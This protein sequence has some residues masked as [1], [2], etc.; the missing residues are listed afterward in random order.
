MQLEIEGA[1]PM[2]T[3]VTIDDALYEMALEMAEPNTDKSEIFRE[4][5]KTFV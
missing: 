3:T 5:M 4:A 1:P 2:R